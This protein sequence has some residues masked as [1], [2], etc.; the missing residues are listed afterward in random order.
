[1]TCPG[2]GRGVGAFE[3][4]VQWLVR[5]RDPDLW[6]YQWRFA[7]NLLHHGWIARGYE[8]AVAAFHSAMETDGVDVEVSTRIRQFCQR[9]EVTHPEVRT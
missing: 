2:P 3:D 8:T 1:L 6:R 7:H 4:S 5:I 9:L